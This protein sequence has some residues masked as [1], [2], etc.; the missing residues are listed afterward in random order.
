MLG[1]EFLN[2]HF[3]IEKKHVGL[4]RKVCVAVL[5]TKNGCAVIGLVSGEEYHVV[6]SLKD[7]VEQMTGGAMDI[8]VDDCPPAIRQAQRENPE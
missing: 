3:D 7:V 8:T 6:E 5:R 1:D 2:V 4:I